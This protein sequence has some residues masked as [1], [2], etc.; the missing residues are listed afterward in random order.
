M[1]LKEDIE[2][3]IHV[4]GAWK[5]RF[6]DFL[7]G[8]AAL[9]L[10]TIGDTQ[11]CELGRWL[12]QEGRWLLPQRDHDEICKLHAEFHRVVGEIIQKIKRKDFDAARHDLARGGGF[13]QAS[14]ALTLALSKA[15]LHSP[16][17]PTELEAPI[18]TVEPAASGSST[19]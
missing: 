10:S 4:H 6:R 14:H 12:G 7:S 11:V 15:A 8:K 13:E 5:A 19:T 18:A 9:D 1:S 16:P 17:K 3:A 2:Q